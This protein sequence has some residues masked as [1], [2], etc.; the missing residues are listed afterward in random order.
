MSGVEWLQKR[1]T[2]ER[3]EADWRRLLPELWREARSTPVSRWVDEDGLLG[4]VRAHR[5]EAI[6]AAWAKAVAQVLEDVRAE[7]AEMEESP[8]VLFGPEAVSAAQAIAARPGL[9]PEAWIRHLFAQPAADMLIADTLYRS[10]RDFSTAVP[11]VIQNLLPGFLGRFAKMGTGVVASVAEEVEKRLE[12]EV[13]RFVDHGSQKALERA[14]DFAV[15]QVDSEQAVAARRSFVAFAAQQQVAHTAALLP[16]PSETEALLAAAGRHWARTETAQQ[17]LERGLRNWFARHADRTV[18]EAL[19]A[20]GLGEFDPPFDAW[21]EAT[22]PILRGL[23]TLPAA[24]AWLAS[25]PDEN[26][27]Q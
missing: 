22:W 14:A 24:R 9:P 19:D 7:L 16:E 12:P 5:K 4:L 6:A 11:R 3:A 25:L 17:A 18:G 8:E 20:H 13:K 26:P 2:D 27:E 21:A 10:V 23:L 1:L 15:G